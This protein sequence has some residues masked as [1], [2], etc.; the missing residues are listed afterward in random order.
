[1]DSRGVRVPSWL[2][3][4]VLIV[5]ALLVLPSSASAHRLSMAKANSLARGHVIQFWEK[6]EWAESKRFKGC[7]RKGPHGIVCRGTVSG[8]YTQVDGS[9]WDRRCKLR[10]DVLLRTLGGM[11]FILDGIA[12]VKC[13]NSP[14]FS[15]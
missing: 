15:I 6:H 7:H 5:L 2:L 11:D 14:P 8:S 4:L 3:P 10:I 1:M 9:T 12:F 13:T